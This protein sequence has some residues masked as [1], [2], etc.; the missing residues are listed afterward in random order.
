MSKSDKS[1]AKEQAKAAIIKEIRGGMIGE[2]LESDS[3]LELL[4]D[5]QKTE[6]FVNLFAMIKACRGVLFRVDI[7]TRRKKQV[8]VHTPREQGIIA[9]REVLTEKYQSYPDKLALRK[10][11]FNNVNLLI[12]GKVK[13][14]TL[15]PGIGY[16]RLIQEIE[17][18][19]DKTLNGLKF[20]LPKLK[21]DNLKDGNSDKKP[22]EKPTEKQETKPL[23]L[24]S[25]VDPASLSHAERLREALRY[26]SCC[27]ELLKIADGDEDLIQQVLKLKDAF[28]TKLVKEQQKAA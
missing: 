1:I 17:E 7:V 18:M 22:T 12:N 8:E 9:L 27:N 23:A 24:D 25:G 10:T 28:N 6:I 19:E 2:L 13:N 26:L 20:F 21:P 4:A 5:K 15:I 11:I 14:K 3:N 16:D